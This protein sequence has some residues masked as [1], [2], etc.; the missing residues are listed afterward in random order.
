MHGGR[1]HDDLRL[2]WQAAGVE[3]TA[4]SLWA[5]IAASMVVHLKL[6]NRP[7]KVDWAHL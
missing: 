6:W 1:F 2:L 7:R 4:D 5:G 3:L